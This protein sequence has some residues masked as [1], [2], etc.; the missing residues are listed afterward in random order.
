M[1]KKRREIT[2]PSNN[3]MYTEE[4]REN[5]VDKTNFPPM[6]RKKGSP[7]EPFIEKMKKI[8]RS[9]IWKKK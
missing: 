7:N 6:Q 2:M 1:H 9:K 5:T 4:M 8:S 3:S